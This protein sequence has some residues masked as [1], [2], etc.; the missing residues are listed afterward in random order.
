[1]IPAQRTCRVMRVSLAGGIPAELG[2]VPNIRD[3]RCSAA[4]PCA[5]AQG[6]VSGSG[7]VVHELDLTKGMGREIYR[8]TN[9][10]AGTPDISPDGKWLASPYGAAIVVRSF[11]GGAS[12]REIPVRGASKLVSVDY[13]PDGRGFFTGDLAAT[14]TR[15][16]YVDLS[17]RSTVLWRQPGSSVLWGVPSPDARHIAMVMYTIDSNVYMVE[18]F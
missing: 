8:E 7:L 14:E 10:L 2:V 5:I 12:V 1:V 11:G 3:F 15:L 16:L 18:D 6:I 4:G 13:A 9:S 17:G